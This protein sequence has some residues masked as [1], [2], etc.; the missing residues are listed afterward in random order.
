MNFILKLSYNNVTTIL[1]ILSLKMVFE[2]LNCN[3]ITC[4]ARVWARKYSL[5][6]YNSYINIYYSKIEDLRYTPLKKK[7]PVVRLTI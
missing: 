2:K 5:F 7:T 1:E 4:T 3:V 6:G